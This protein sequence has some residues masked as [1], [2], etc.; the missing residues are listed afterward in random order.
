VSFLV[1]TN[2]VSEIRKGPR[3]DRNVSAWYEAVPDASLYVS[4]LVL[5]EL[6]RGVERKRAQD[7]AQAVALEKWVVSV[8]REFGDRILPVDSSVADEWGRMSAARPVSIIDGLMAATAKV[9]GFTLVT[10]NSAH[11]T[12]LGV[13]VLNPFDVQA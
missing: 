11:V 10:R 13:A 9:R 4:V 6:R 8:Q 7:P 3:A 1:H 5:G 2:I 12:G